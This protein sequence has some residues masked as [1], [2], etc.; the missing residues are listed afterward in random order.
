MRLIIDLAYFRRREIVTRGHVWLSVVHEL[1]N[2][3]FCFFTDVEWKD[4]WGGLEYK[5][6]SKAGLPTHHV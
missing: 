6:H 1:C 5:V 2:V 3:W 4:E